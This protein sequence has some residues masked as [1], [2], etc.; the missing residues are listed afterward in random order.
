VRRTLA[1]VDPLYLAPAIKAA[2]LIATD[3]AGWWEPLRQSLPNTV[4][5]YDVTHE[6]QTDRDAIEGWIA[7]RLAA[8]RLPRTWIPEDIGPWSS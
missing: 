6:G 1:Y 5:T 2:L 8:E 4:E 3:N 7:D